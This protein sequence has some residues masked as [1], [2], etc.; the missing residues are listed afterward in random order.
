[1]TGND[2]LAGHRLVETGTL[3]EFSI[4]K[5]SVEVGPD[6]G[7]FAVRVDLVFNAD[8]GFEAEDIAEWGA[9]GLIFVLRRVVVCRWASPRVIRHRLR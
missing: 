3:V 1:M 4:V 8:E 5:Q 7:E 6:D 2:R 9:F